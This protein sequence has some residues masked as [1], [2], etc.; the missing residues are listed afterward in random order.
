MAKRSYNADTN[1]WE[2]VQPKTKPTPA[3]NTRK[4]MA[5]AAAASASPQKP[6]PKAAN[7]AAG[8]PQKS[9]P[10]PAPRPA[11]VAVAAPVP[12]SRPVR[13]APAKQPVPGL[14][15]PS[16]ANAKASVASQKLKGSV[17]Q[18]KEDPMDAIRGGFAGSAKRMKDA[19]RSKNIIRAY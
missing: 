3:S 10:V 6:A 5:M 16:V 1:K 14:K 9:A 12:K 15:L 17:P 7:K 19:R 4:K 2:V 11:R 13:E 8:K 18:K